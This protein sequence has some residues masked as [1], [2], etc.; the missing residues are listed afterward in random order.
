MRYAIA[1]PL[2]LGLCGCGGE[3]AANAV[4]KAPRPQMMLGAVDLLKPIRAVGTEPYW[5]LDMAP[6][7]IIFTDFAAADPQPEP[8]YAV[9]PAIAGDT[10][11]YTTKNVAGTAVVLA[12]TLD[13][14]TSTGEAGTTEPLAVELRIG[15]R[16]LRGCAGPRPP[17]RPAADNVTANAA[18]P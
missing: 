3:P 2:L 5:T 6:G 1:V 14:C 10:A 16:V 12:L 13:A 18:M 11:T 7:D 4:A 17:E 9:A 15:A 8:F